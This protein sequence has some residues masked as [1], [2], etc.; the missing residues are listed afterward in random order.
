M[1]SMTSSPT[2]ARARARARFSSGENSRPLGFRKSKVRTG[3]GTGM[4]TGTLNT[5]ERQSLFESNLQRGGGFMQQ[6]SRG[7]P[8]S[9]IDGTPGQRVELNPRCAAD[10]GR[11]H[12]NDP[13]IL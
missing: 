9:H 1:Q 5:P 7:I 13:E 8:V 4:G 11:T 10:L 2:R 6:W 12:W 3:T